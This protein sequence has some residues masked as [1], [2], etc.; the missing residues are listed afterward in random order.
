MKAKMRTP[1][2]S[3]AGDKAGSFIGT[4]GADETPVRGILQDDKTKQV[5]H[6]HRQEGDVGN[7]EVVAGRQRAEYFIAY[8]QHLGFGDDKAESLSKHSSSQRGNKRGDAHFRDH[9]TT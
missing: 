9:Q 2:H 5:H 3:D 6:D 7:A 4:N 8:W 1:I